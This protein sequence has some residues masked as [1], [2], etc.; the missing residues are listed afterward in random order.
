M[1]VVLCVPNSLP[2]LVT[3]DEAG[4]HQTTPGQPTFG[5]NVDG[6]VL[7][8]ADVPEPTIIQDLIPY[9]TG[10]LITDRHILSAAHCFDEDESGSIDDIFRDWPLHVRW[11]A[12]L[13]NALHAITDGGVTA[14]DYERGQ[15]DY[16]IQVHVDA[17][18]VSNLCPIHQ[19]F[20]VSCKP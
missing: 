6:V 2:A 19:R 20:R 14:D 17:F 3:S 13:A 5:V 4:S 10:A 15:R 11:V 1:L 9:C 12:F 18:R 16:P 8:A 7:V